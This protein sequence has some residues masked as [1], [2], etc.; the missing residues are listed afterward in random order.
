MN[1]MTSYEAKVLAVLERGGPLSILDIVPMTGFGPA[2]IRRTA[3]LLLEK[4]LVV[5]CPGLG[6]AVSGTPVMPLTSIVTRR[7]DVDGG[8]FRLLLG[9]A[10]ERMSGVPDESIDVVVTSPPYYR[11]RDYKAAGQIGWEKT[12]ELFAERLLGVLRQIAR[13]LRKHGLAFVVFDDTRAKGKLDCIDSLVDVGLSRVGLE[14]VQEITWLK[15]TVKPNGQDLSHITERIYV[16]RRTGCSHYWDMF[17]ARQQAQGGGMRRMT[18]VW[19][20]PCNTSREAHG[21]HYAMFPEELV[22]RCLEIAAPANGVCRVC[23][24]PWI[25]SLKR[26]ETLWQKHKPQRSSIRRQAAEEGKPNHGDTRKSNFFAATLEHTGWQSSCQHK[27]TPVRAVIADP[28]SGSGTTGKVALQLGHDYI[29][30]DINKGC[31]SYAANRLK[32]EVRQL[33]GRAM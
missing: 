32:S 11:R 27:G 5:S 28:F 8:A 4:D 20:I 10:E 15:T 6:W 23:G 33:V 3:E 16:F 13:A 26:G 24:A 7:G 19:E 14:K 12:P 18:D 31:I 25:R 17:M 9:D 30:V 21:S 1:F 29:G 2:V 22:R